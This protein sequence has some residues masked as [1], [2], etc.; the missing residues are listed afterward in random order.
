MANFAFDTLKSLDYST[1]T[2]GMDGN[3]AG[4]VVTRVEFTGIKQGK[5]AKQNFLTRQIAKVP[6][7]FN[8]N[9][10][11]PFYSL[12]SSMNPEPPPGVLP[13]RPPGAAGETLP[14]PANSVQPPASP[15]KP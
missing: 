14:P 12:V 4:D 8:V 2:I 11:A 3:L 6:I 5:D 13:F 1:M 10:H 9:V 15:A 7:K